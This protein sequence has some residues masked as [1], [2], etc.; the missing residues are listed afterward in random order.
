MAFL[1]GLFYCDLFCRDF[2]IRT[3]YIEAIFIYLPLTPLAAAQE[4]P[5]EE[6][7]SEDLVSS[8]QVVDDEKIQGD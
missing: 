4:G 7:T 5:Y 6:V 2:S 8:V 1:S 3:F